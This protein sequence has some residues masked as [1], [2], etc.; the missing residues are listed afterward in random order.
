MVHPRWRSRV[1]EAPGQALRDC[2]P[3][4]DLGQHQYA[5]VRGQAAAV[6][7]SMYRL[8]GDRRREDGPLVSFHDAL[9]DG[10]G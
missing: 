1:R 5:R 8:A 9:Q 7:G 10:L 4:L 2:E 3:A 6:E